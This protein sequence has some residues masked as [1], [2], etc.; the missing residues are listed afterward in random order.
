MGEVDVVFCGG[1]E[2]IIYWVSLVGFVVV[3]VLFSDFN[4]SFEC[5]LCFFD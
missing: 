3:C 4:D 2:V 5:V 1:V